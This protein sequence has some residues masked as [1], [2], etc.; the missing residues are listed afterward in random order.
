[1]KFIHIAD[2]HLGAVPDPGCPW[3]ASRE[4]EIW[5]TFERLIEVIAKERIDLL[6]IAGDLFHRQPLLRQLREVNYLFSTIPDTEVVLMAGNHDYMGRESTYRKIRWAENVHMFLS[7]K[8]D[9][10]YFPRLQTTVYG[11]SYEKREISQSLYRDMKPGAEEG[12]HILLAHGGDAQHIPLGPMDGREF[13]YVALGHIHKPGILR[14]YQMAYAGALE[15]LDR[16]DTGAHGFVYGVVQDGQV[17]TKLIPFACRSYVDL[18]I[19][20]TARTVQKELEQQ[21]RTQVREQGEK[22]L[23][24]IHLTGWRNPELSPDQE[25]L[26]CCGNITDIL[27]ETRPYYDLER[28]KQQQEG[29]LIGEYIYRLEGQRGVTVEK[30]LYYGLEA[31]LESQESL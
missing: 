24:R 13:T 5:Q 21:V 23:Y 26:R 10:F 14:P 1:M 15:P 17:R 25:R 9:Q 20:M 6:L 12:I 29:T 31:L 2:V 19:P 30:A 22:N 16:N 8:P 28:L 27:D 3:S 7:Q 11:L 18:E 4:K